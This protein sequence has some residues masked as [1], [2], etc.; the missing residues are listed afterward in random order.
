[1][2]S[3]TLLLL[4]GCGGGESDTGTFVCD[5]EVYIC[6][7]AAWWQRQQEAGGFTDPMDGVW[8]DSVVLPGCIGDEWVYAATSGGLTNGANL[9]NAWVA[10]QAGGYNEEQPLD[11]A[12]SDPGGQWDELETRLFAG[13]EEGEVVPGERTALQCGTHDTDPIMSYAV[14]LYDADGNLADCAVFTTRMATE[15]SID[16]LFDPASDTNPVTA[17]DE[18]TRANCLTW[19]LGG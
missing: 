17:R 19:S 4:A 12:F 3:L 2:I 5:T 18:L 7:T 6:D 10:P 1:M 16:E 8:I 15:Q 11:V 14:R 13:V 9:V